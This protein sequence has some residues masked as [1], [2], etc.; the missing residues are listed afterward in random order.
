[1]GSVEWVDERGHPIPGHPPFIVEDLGLS[2]QPPTPPV[3]ID[4][5]IYPGQAALAGINWDRN[6]RAR[7]I[8]LN[9]QAQGS[10]R[11]V[12]LTIHVLDA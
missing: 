4:F 10:L 1:M 2:F 12:G 3:V 8:V 11:M 5:E 6:T 9:T 7:V